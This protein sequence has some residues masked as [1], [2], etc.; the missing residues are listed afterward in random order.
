MAAAAFCAGCEVG[1]SQRYPRPGNDSI[2]PG[3]CPAASACFNIVPGA[4]GPLAATRLLL[5]WTP[6]N[7]S[8]PPE[9]AA[10]A[11]LSGAERSLVLALSA[12][13]PPRATIDWGQA[14]G[15]VFAVPPESGTPNP[16]A[17]VGI[18]Q[19]MFVHAVDAHRQTP[20]MTNKF[21][22]GI[23]EG[24]AAYRMQ[25]GRM[26]DNFVLAE[27]GAVFDLGICPTPT[28]RCNLPSPNPK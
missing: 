10:L 28:P 22:A 8:R 2:A 4:P 21:P 20:L 27:R 7:E 25:R 11:D 1:P 13:P 5:F 15:Y 23:A 16:D 24:T 17:A 9:I 18:A 19:M 3:A 12:I 26:F 6:P 14:W